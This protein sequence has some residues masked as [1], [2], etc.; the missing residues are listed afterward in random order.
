MFTSAINKFMRVSMKFYKIAVLM[1]I[2]SSMIFAQEKELTKVD[3]K[4]Q[5]QKVSYSIGYDI[6]KNFKMQGMD[7]SLPEFIEGIKAGISGNSIL[8]D[9]EI[10]K[11]LT[12]FQ[13]EMTA[14]Y[15]SENKELSE[16]NIREGNE[17][18]LA[19]KKKEGVDTTASGLQYKIIKK[20]EGGAKP[21]ATDNVTVHYRG[22]FINGETFDS[23]YDRNEPITFPLMNVIPGWTEG[24]QLMTVGDKYEFYIPY[25]LAY[26]ESGKMPVIEPCKTLLFEVELISIGK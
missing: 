13:Q 11:C 7:I 22:F 15:E 17:F 10:F 2:S 18:L 12:E 9:E 21:S 20:G 24:L 4:T 16:K 26:G 19:N 6:G 1:L 14:K 23:S 8:T 25:K 5:E 3:L